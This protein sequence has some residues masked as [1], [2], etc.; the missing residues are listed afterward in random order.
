MGALFLSQPSSWEDVA[1]ISQ[2]VGARLCH[3]LASPLGGVLGGIEMLSSSPNEADTELHEWL[4]KMRGHLRERFEFLR[5]CW[6]GTFQHLEGETLHGLLQN[7]V[8]NQPQWA[9]ELQ[10]SPEMLLL[11]KG[12]GSL[13][14]FLFLWLF[15]RAP[16]GGNI[17]VDVLSGG[18]VLNLQAS[19]SLLAQDFAPPQEITPHTLPLT[20]AFLL[21]DVHRITL[22]C[23]PTSGALHVQGKASKK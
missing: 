7:Y 13:I 12:W 8:K 15:S 21:A 3:D 5:T 4:Q 16:R 18:F 1:R 14:L 2:M 10:A 19:G 22:L 20:M 9:V 23:H 17:G 6:S 11:P